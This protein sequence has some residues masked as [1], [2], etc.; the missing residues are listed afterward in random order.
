[1]KRNW[2]KDACKPA[3]DAYLSM[4]DHRQITRENM[5][6]QRIPQRKIGE[7]IDVKA[8]CKVT[9][10]AGVEDRQ[11]RTIPTGYEL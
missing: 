7:Y 3:K 8:G 11:F 6:T 1:M 5:D 4:K 9:I 10:L 2:V